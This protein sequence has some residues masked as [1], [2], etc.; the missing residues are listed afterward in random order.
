[1]AKAEIRTAYGEAL[2]DLGAEN[3]RVVAL[4]ADLSGSTKSALFGKAHPDRFF[5]VGI[6]ELNMVAMAAGMSACGLIPFV[7]TFAVF[8]ALRAADPIQSL[9]AHDKLNVKLAGAYGGMSDSYDGSSHQAITDIAHMRALPNM[10]VVCVCDAVETKKAVK[11]VSEMDGPVYLRLSRAFTDILFDD[12]YNFQIGRGV[13]LTEG[14]DVTIVATGYMVQKSLAAAE[15]LKTQ[16]ISARVVNIHTIK[17]IDAELLAACARDTGAVVTVE[18]HNIFGGL[19]GAVAEALAQ[20][21][22]VPIEM[23]GMEDCFGQSGDY[24]QLLEKYGLYPDRIAAAAKA[25]IARK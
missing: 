11:A 5:N 25:A 2:R 24:E 6:A 21:C 18:E 12:S 14:K 13:R 10:T 19:G 23:V 8:L 1:M 22:P 15:L 9:I 3:P 4:D 17:P 16:G 7:N 20:T